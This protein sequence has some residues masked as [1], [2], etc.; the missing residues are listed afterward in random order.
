MLLLYALLIYLFLAG[1]FLSRRGCCSLGCNDLIYGPNKRSN[2]GLHGFVD[3]AVFGLGD[4]GVFRVKIKN[5]PG[6][7]SKLCESAA[8][9]L[10]CDVLTSEVIPTVLEGVW[11]FKCEVCANPVA[12]QI[13]DADIKV[14]TLR[15]AAQSQNVRS[16][17]AIGSLNNEE[18]RIMIQRQYG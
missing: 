15:G 11:M 2:E 8:C 9:S 7:E 6:C 18:F 3:V 14:S 17:S 10:P 5:R 13:C 16:N 12:T 4:W 1:P